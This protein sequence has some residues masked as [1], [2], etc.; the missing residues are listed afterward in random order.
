MRNVF[1]KYIKIFNRFFYPDGC[2][3][4]SVPNDLIMLCKHLIDYHLGR[5]D[6]EFVY[7][8]KVIK[9]ITRTDWMVTTG[10]TDRLVYMMVTPKVKVCHS[11]QNPRNSPETSSAKFIADLL[12]VNN[13]GF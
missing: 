3:Y 6:Q 5:A 12:I 10:Y 4:F 9:K 13:S 8:D 2:N 1:I 7:S 11:D